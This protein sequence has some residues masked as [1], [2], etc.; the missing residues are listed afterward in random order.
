MD[1]VTSSQQEMDLADKVDCLIKI[2]EADLDA[3]DFKWTLF[4]TAAN[5][6]KFDSL[7]KPFPSAYVTNKVLNIN[8]LRTTI[9]SI[10]RFNT[11]LQMLRNFD[12]SSDGSETVISDAA[13]NLL[14]WC[15]LGVKEPT[16]KS[17]DRLNV[18]TKITISLKLNCVC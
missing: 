13:I 16:L 15:L 17:I 10:P 5:H 18:S 6:Y 12:K 3:C 2:L 1:S 7:L 4:V 8:D 14:Y 9:A 11:L